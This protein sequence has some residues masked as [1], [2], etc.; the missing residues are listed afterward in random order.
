MDLMSMYQSMGIVAKCVAV[1]LLIMSMW[2]IGVG[3]ERFFTYQQARDAVEAVRAAGGQAPQ[4]RPSEGRRG[5]LDVQE[6]PLQPPRQGR[7]RRPAGISVPAGERRR[8]EPRGPDGHRAPRRFSA[9]R[10]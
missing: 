1:M 8:P 10:R 6:L 4:G 5:A 7:A 9:R 3:I 2:S